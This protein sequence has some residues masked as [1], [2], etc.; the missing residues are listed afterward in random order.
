MT[1]EVDEIHL[2]DMMN[3]ALEKV[4]DAIEETYRATIAEEGEP[5][6]GTLRLDIDLGYGSV[7]EVDYF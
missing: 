4:R 6:L 7:N 1:R 3:R 2:R 5:G